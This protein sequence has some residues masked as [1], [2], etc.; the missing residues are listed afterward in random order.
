[1]DLPRGAVMG[2]ALGRTQVSTM[3]TG[4]WIGS[5]IV[6]KIFC[7]GF[8]AGDGLAGRGDD[9]RCAGPHPGVHHGNGLRAGGSRRLHRRAGRQQF[10][11][12]QAHGCVSERHRLLW[13]LLLYA[14]AKPP[15]AS[16]AS[17]PSTTAVRQVHT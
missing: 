13:Q 10:A 4:S 16:P 3:A 14:F 5:S 15:M 6:S 1:M 8:H 7:R 2:A 12:A 11:V 17:W 9:G